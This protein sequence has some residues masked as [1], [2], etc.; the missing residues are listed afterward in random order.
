MTQTSDFVENT[1]DYKC[2]HVIAVWIV[3]IVSLRRHVEKRYYRH[4]LI[5]KSSLNK[6]LASEDN[7]SC[8]F[9]GFKMNLNPV[10]KGNLGLFHSISIFD[11]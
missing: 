8:F 7:T 11:L 1:S 2:G 9:A 3:G 5:N 10:H 4:P 6:A